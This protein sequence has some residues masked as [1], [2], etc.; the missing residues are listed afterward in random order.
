M[1]QSF[2]FKVRVL[3]I[4]IT[5]FLINTMFRRKKT[6]NGG[7]DCDISAN[8]LGAAGKFLTWMESLNISILCR[9]I[10]NLDSLVCIE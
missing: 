4:T 5:L 2:H 1:Y 9:L 10:L 6:Y 3:E 7:V 8:R